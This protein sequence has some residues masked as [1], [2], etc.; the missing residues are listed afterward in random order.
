MSWTD[1]FYNS[2]AWEA[3][4]EARLEKDFYLCQSCLRNHEI[5]TATMVHHKKHLRDFPELGLDIDNL[6]SLCDACHNR[7]HPEKIKRKKT[8]TKNH[9]IRVIDI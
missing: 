3:A 5:T 1:K 4:R 7:A 2:K 9:R 8:E 6:E